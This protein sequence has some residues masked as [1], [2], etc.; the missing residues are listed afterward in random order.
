[1]A[2]DE[3]PT[4]ERSWLERNLSAFMIGIFGTVISGLMVVMVG[5]VKDLRTD[6]V[7]LD[8]SL[9]VLQFE[10]AST[11][12]TLADEVSL[13]ADEVS[14]IDD[15]IIQSIGSVRADL[16]IANQH[17]TGIDTHLALIKRE[18]SAPADFSLSSADLSSE[19]SPDLTIAGS[20]GN[21]QRDK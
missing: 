2:K 8:S 10:V 17:L 12:T 7:R 16:S 3:S 20:G 21:A 4:K 9:S 18:F 19:L 6:L 5:S 14:L 1:M 11:R 15:G 13:I